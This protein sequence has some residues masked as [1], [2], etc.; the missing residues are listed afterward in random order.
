MPVYNTIVPYLKEAVDSILKHLPDF[1][2]MKFEL[3]CFDDMT[4]PSFLRELSDIHMGEWKKEYVNKDVLD[5]TQWSVDIRY[6]NGEKRHFSGS[7][8]FPY[9]FNDFLALMRVEE[10]G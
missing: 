8:M 3:P 9:N 4:R 1:D 7:N 2:R 5:G 10:E 6:N